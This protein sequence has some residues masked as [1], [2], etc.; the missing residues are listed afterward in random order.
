MA[1]LVW[2]ANLVTC[3]LFNTLHSQVYAGMGTRGGISRERFFFYGFLA[4][5][6]WYFFPGYIFQALSVFNWVCWI[7]PNNVV[8]NQLFGYSSGLVRSFTWLTR[9][10]RTDKSSQGM[11]L[12]TFDWAQ[13]AYIGSP[14]ATP[15]WAEA[16]VAGGFVF[17]F[18]ECITAPSDV[19]PML[20]V[21][22][23]I[24]TPILYYTNVWYSQFM[25]CVVLLLLGVDRDLIP[26]LCSISSRTSFDRFGQTYDVTKIINDDASLNL[27]KYE[28]YSPL[29]LSTTFALSYGLSFA[30]I[31]ATLMHTLLYFRKQIWVQ[32]RRAMSEQPDIHARL[33]SKYPQV[34]EWWYGMIFSE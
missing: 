18:C 22:T 29:F 16:N 2:P 28:Q 1:I 6:C 17:F 13:I 23:G 31:T 21:Q 14:L 15:W 5:T 3:A 32:S 30:S 7:V 20:T 12:I 27:A 19:S 8:V 4:S 33:M 11:S 34:P 9:H 25:P 26:H 24:I 10:P